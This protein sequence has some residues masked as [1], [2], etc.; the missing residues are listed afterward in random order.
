MSADRAYQERDF[1]LLREFESLDPL[2]RVIGRMHLTGPGWIAGAVLISGLLPASLSL[3]R[4]G[5]T[6]LLWV[7]L[8]SLALCAV[9]LLIIGR[10]AVSSG[11][12]PLDVLSDGI[13]PMVSRA[14]TIAA[15]LTAMVASLP[16]FQIAADIT[17]HSL[18]PSLSQPES[19]LSVATVLLAL[20]AVLAL[21]SER[22]GGSMKSFVRSVKLLLGLSGL[23][24]AC[25]LIKLMNNAGLSLSG[26]LAGLFPNP[27][28]L[29][30]P[31]ASLAEPLAATGAFEDFW[32]AQV[33]D[34]QR[35]AIAQTLMLTIAAGVTFL[36]P[37][38]I[39]RRGWDRTMFRRQSRFDLLA[40]MVLP[41]LSI[42]IC[43]MAA[44]AVT[45]HGQAM[46]GL[47]GTAVSSD[48]SS[49]SVSPALRERY[50]TLL[51][52]RVR[53][54]HP[55]AFRGLTATAR[56]EQARDYFPSLPAADRQI[57]AML[58]KRD[59]SDLI[60][61]L[62]PVTGRTLAHG[63]FALLML[64][65]AL[66]GIAGLMLVSG[67]A[68]CELFQCPDR[69]AYRRLG[70][71]LPVVGL[72]GP[73]VW[74]GSVEAQMTIPL[75]IFSATTLTIV[76]LSFWGLL[77]SPSLS[78]RDLP[79]RDRRTVWNLLGGLTCAVL[80]LATAWIIMDATGPA[81]LTAIAFLIVLL[82]FLH[83]LN[84]TAPA[85]ARRR[86]QAGS[87]LKGTLRGQSSGRP[88]TY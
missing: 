27:L 78:G 39:A 74:T 7:P 56:R 40:G 31:A 15:L 53:T 34:A 71:A 6:G 64:T 69:A 55:A 35:D 37:F 44:A 16:L 51:V 25:V 19:R 52:E 41:V 87:D 50:E 28:L 62:V 80:A 66:T 81:G 86:L 73:F 47:T 38:V 36:F 29:T 49:A 43:V 8:L 59:A 20:A 13:S 75:Q 77:N 58:V 83:V 88:D 9:L 24:A 57:A 10:V 3:G 21:R 45:V 4:I 12:R 14:W 23:A 84:E 79:R 48:S 54:E 70:C 11:R 68:F 5:G 30:Q 18:L 1:L 82:A 85:R 63:F 76:A 67:T 65:A 72:V 26:I 33:V 61:A 17:Q 46:D 2:L 22:H 60:A 32:M 42:T